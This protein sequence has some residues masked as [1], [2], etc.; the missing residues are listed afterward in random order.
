MKFVLIHGAFGN[1]NNHWLLNLKKRL[2]NTNQQ[3]LY[4]QFPVDN[5]DDMTQRGLNA[6]PLIK[7]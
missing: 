2:E 7:A 3:V 4:V 6:P 5:W 1:I